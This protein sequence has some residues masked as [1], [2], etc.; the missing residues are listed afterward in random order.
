MKPGFFNT[1]I[2]LLKTSRRRAHGRSKRRKQLLNHRTGNSNDTLQQLGYVMMILFMGGLHI[3][4]AFAVQ[5]AIKEAQ[6]FSREQKGCV[7]VGTRFRRLVKELQETEFEPDRIHIQGKLEA[8]YKVEV[9]RRVEKFGGSPEEHEQFLRRLVKEHPRTAF[10]SN[11]KAKPGIKALASSDSFVA[12]VGSFTLIWWLIMLT[13]QGEGLELDLQRRRH[14]MWEWLLSHPV[15]PGAVFLAEMVAPFAANPVY[16]TAPLFFGFLFGL[17]YGAAFGILALFL[18]GLPMAL[19][20]ACLGKALE[21]S[22]M[23]RCP[24]RSRGAIIGLMGWLGYAALI[25]FFFGIYAMPKIVNAVGGLLHPLAQILPSPMLGWFIGARPD[26]SFSF[27]QG[28]GVCWIAA[29]LMIGCGVGI[30]VWSTQKGL[31][32][33][34]ASS[35]PTKRS[36]A[37]LHFGKDPLYRKEMLWFIR[38][39]SAI[40]QVILIPIT[41]ASVQLFN[42]R[43]V[44]EHA[45]G[46]WHTL[47]GTAVVFGTYFLWIL[48]PR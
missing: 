48:G 29:L 37:G 47:A 6:N 22:I 17:A 9:D 18:A 16:L 20:A 36:K 10:I 42:L 7:V 34:T 2:L 26:G 33:N 11:A 4:S 28:L 23:L 24:P 3:A 1:V 8:R 41:I 13:F 5:Y 25:S 27:F 38:D 39:R 40:V 45:S 31:S 12:M 44:L 19:A 46:A 15:Q 14:P 43:N 30:S 21:I 35:Q 32:G